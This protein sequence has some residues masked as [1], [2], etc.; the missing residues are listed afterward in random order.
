MSR[1]LK[2]AVANCRDTR[3]RPVVLD[4]GLAQISETSKSPRSP[5]LGPWAV[6][7]PFTRQVGAVWTCRRRCFGLEASALV[8]YAAAFPLTNLQAKA[9]LFQKRLHPEF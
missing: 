9:R 1:F 3:Y 2:G 7:Q 8:C 6:S 4:Q 5:D